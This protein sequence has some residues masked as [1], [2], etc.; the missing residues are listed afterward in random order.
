MTNQAL[1]FNDWTRRWMKE[2]QYQGPEV[3]EVE[4]RIARVVAL[5]EEPIPTGW[6]RAQDAR[7][8]EPGRRY[9]R[10]HRGGQG[11]P[12][13]EHAIEF[14]ILDPSPMEA[15]TSCLGAQLID[16]VN[17]LPL[18]KDQGGGRAGNV[19]ADMLLLVRYGSEYKLLLVEVKWT[20]N[21][22]WYAAVENL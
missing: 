4:A 3:P 1:P 6:E 13:G 16:G 22:A 18:A 21:N 9:C 10:T 7:L 14:E 19:E 2:A 17:A 8:L 11:V 5:W 15:S 20:S 12:R